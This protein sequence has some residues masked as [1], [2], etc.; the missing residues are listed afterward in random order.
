MIKKFFIALVGSMIFF[1][2]SKSNEEEL[3]N[4]DNPGGGGSNC[5]TA[6]MKY[7]ANVVPI[8]SSHCYSCH[9]VSTNANSNGI[10]LEGHDKLLPY[11]TNGTLISVITHAPGYPQMPQGGAKLSA[12]NINIIRSWINNG[13]QNN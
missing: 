8:L 4:T 12:C 13:A 3:Q 11:A 2:C 5:D 6:N 10:I 7:T 9:G 1:A